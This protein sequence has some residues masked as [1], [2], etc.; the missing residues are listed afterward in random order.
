MKAEAVEE[1]K[2]PE[3]PEVED[4]QS[5]KRASLGRPMKDIDE[6]RYQSV[7][8]AFPPKTLKQVVDQADEN[9]VSRSELVVTA[10]KTH[11]RGITEE[12]FNATQAAEK[13]LAAN[14]PI[15]ET[16]HSNDCE[17]QYACEYLGKNFTDIAPFH[18]VTLKAIKDQ[19][20]TR[21]FLHNDYETF[22]SLAAKSL[23]IE[24]A[25]LSKKIDEAI[26]QQK[27]FEKPDA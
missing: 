20:S 9:E 21:G 12:K 15:F 26:E 7:S 11:L 23:E 24:P 2:A 16:L 13:A 25:D 19:L 22:L 3:E 6:G 1:E 4:S 27:V 17:G 8:I 10:V 14:L 5:D 18:P